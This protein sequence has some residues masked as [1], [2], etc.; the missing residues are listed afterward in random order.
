[1][2][3]IADRSHAG[4]F[5]SVAELPGLLPDGVVAHPGSLDVEKLHDRAYRVVREDLDRALV[6]DLE[7]AA[8]TLGQ[9]RATQD[10]GAAAEAAVTGRVQRLFVDRLTRVPEHVETVGGT[11]VE[12]LGDEDA[13]DEICA[14]AIR[15][16][17]AEVRVFEEGR[18]GLPPLVAELRG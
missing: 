16:G 3:L 14:L 2:V 10:V 4:R 18:G 9:G 15:R 17:G 5:R 8:A 11:L 6:A 13:L 12:A 1:V 7:R